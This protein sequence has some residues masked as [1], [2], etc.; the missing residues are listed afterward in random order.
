M[1]V[2]YWQGN[3]VIESE[4]QH[5]I[6]SITCCVCFSVELL[7]LSPL[8]IYVLTTMLLLPSVFA[9]H[10][11]QPLD[12]TRVSFSAISLYLNIPHINSTHMQLLSFFWLHSANILLSLLFSIF[13][14]WDSRKHMYIYYLATPPLAGIRLPVWHPL[15]FPPSLPPTVS[16][17]LRILLHLSSS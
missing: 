8:Y 14:S 10:L 4:C 17:T 12:F 3:P 16:L 5:G 1:Q 15:P 6:R 13:Y 9:P 7:P 11:L 2:K